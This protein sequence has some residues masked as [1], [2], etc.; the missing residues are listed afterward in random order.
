MAGRLLQEVSSLFLLGYVLARRS[1]RI[2]DIGLRWSFRD[3]GVGLLVAMGFPRSV[4]SGS[5]G[6]PTDPTHYL[7]NF[8]YRADRRHILLPPW[9]LGPCRSR[10]SIH[11]LKSDRAG[12][13]H[14]RGRRPHWFIGT[15]CCGK[16]PL[17]SSYH[18]YYGWAGA[19]SIALCSLPCRCTTLAHAAHSY[20]RRP[21][22]L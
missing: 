3:V 10:Y 12:L 8:R 6:R 22:F 15:R 16:R 7:W 18:L 14:D 20:H 4:R 5:S 21:C 13:P 1:R 19:T 11:F 2:R 17:Q 9:S